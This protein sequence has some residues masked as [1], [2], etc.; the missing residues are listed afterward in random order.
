VN[1]VDGVRWNAAFAYLDPVR[2]RPNLRIEGNMLVDR[3]LVQQGRVTGV[4]VISP[5][6]PAR[7]ETGQVILCGGAYGSPVVLL[8]SG[9]GAPDDL[10]AMGIELV[11]PLPG[12]GQNLH[13]HPAMLLTYSGS[14]ALIA[15]MEAYIATGRRIYEEHSIV[16]A[17]SSLCEGAFDLHIYPVGGR[18]IYRDGSWFFS[19][20]VAVLDPRSR[21]SLRL[22]SCDPQAAPILD[23]GYLTDDSDHDLAVLLE[24]VAL[25]R[26]LARQAPLAGLVGEELAP[27]AHVLEPEALRAAIRAGGQHYYHPVG[28]CKMGPASDPLAVVDASGHVHG[29]EG[30]VVADA[31]IMPVIPRAN[32]NIPTVVIGEK[33]AT[34]LLA[35]GR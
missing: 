25:A 32:T 17:R 10:R 35:G 22:A 21:G 30:L 1:I 16:K 14:P 31:S 26:R 4:Q 8:R 19:L 27:G 29:L 9:I 18:Q 23:H 7:I 20:P 24:G 12:V 13:D 5:Q 6:G 11:H 3:V 28:T 34:A 2:G 15:A 33:I